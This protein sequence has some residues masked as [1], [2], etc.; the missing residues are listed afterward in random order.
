MILQK[1]FYKPLHLIASVLF[2]LTAAMS[3]L[4]AAGCKSES[5]DAAAHRPAYTP[6]PNAQPPIPVK[7]KKDDL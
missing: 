5:A 7:N 2:V 6:P 1:R 3:F 4:T